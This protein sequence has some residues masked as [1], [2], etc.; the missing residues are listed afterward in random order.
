MAG[1]VWSWLLGFAPVQE[2]VRGE[3][4]AAV[5]RVMDDTEEAQSRQRKRHRDA[6]ARTERELTDV[7]TKLAEL[8]AANTDLL[9][10]NASLRGEVA[11]M[12]EAAQRE[13]VEREEFA[14]RLVREQ[15]AAAEQQWNGATTDV[16]CCQSCWAFWFL[17]T[18]PDRTSCT[19]RGPFGRHDAACGVCAE[20]LV[21]LPAAKSVVLRK[22]AEDRVS[23]PVLDD[24]PRSDIAVANA[25]LA[26]V[27]EG[28][29][30][31]PK[32]PSR[33]AAWVATGLVGLPDLPA[34][35]LGDIASRT[36]MPVPIDGIVAGIRAF[37]EVGA[38]K[39]PSVTAPGN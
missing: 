12:A 7:R 34:K 30:R 36:T 29:A 27:A 24:E 1:R 39:K 17:S 22:N 35:V 28:V 23:R 26:A 9:G 25:E 18:A 2:A 14:Q 15:E 31:L 16:F 21:A 32:V 19:V 8:T 3:V 4:R 6:L 13:V 38:P 11:E 37:I 20:P 10:A 33:T 5:E